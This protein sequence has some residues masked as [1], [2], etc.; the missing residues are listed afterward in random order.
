MISA[1]HEIFLIIPGNHEIFFIISSNHDNIILLIISGNHEIREVQETFSYKDECLQ[2]FGESLGPEVWEA[3]NKA[4][5]AM[6]IA[7][8]VD[9]KVG[10]QCTGL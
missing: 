1:N 9:H 4:F 10:T 3:T 2:K 5:D 6:P 7:A 8:V